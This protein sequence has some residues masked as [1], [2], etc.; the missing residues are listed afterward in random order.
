MPSGS[1][2]ALIIAVAG[3]IVSSIGIVAVVY[4][5]EPS[6]A[7]EY[8][9]GYPYAE[10]KIIQVKGQITEIIHGVESPDGLSS[11]TNIQLDG[12]LT[13]PLSNQ[14]DQQIIEGDNVILEIEHHL[15]N[16]EI[17]GIITSWRSA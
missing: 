5:P 8:L 6:T 1:N 13:F 17:Y 9:E 4:V 11:T 7:A 14:A 16:G 15:I 12:V 10:G 3:L 2:M